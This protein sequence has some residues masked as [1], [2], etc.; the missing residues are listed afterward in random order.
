LVS[1]HVAGTNGLA[2]LLWASAAVG[3]VSYGLPA[4]VGTAMA[5]AAVAGT[6]K[7]EGS[8]T[9]AV[10]VALIALRIIIRSRSIGEQRV[11]VQTPTG[12]QA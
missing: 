2:D 5:L 7:A 9:A 4:T 1:L 8:I 12:I 6:T 3:A 10:I 11:T